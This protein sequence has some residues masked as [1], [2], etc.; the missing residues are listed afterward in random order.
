MAMPKIFI[1]TKAGIKFTTRLVSVINGKFIFYD[2]EN[3]QSVKLEAS[4][5]NWFSILD[6]ETFRPPDDKKKDT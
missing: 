4:K 2:L 3:Q 1:Q 6:I 5:V